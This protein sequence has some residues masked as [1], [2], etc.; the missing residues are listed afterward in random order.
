MTAPPQDRDRNLSTDVLRGL[1][2]VLVVFGHAGRGAIESA[3]GRNVEV[4]SFLDFAL[5]TTH[6]PVFFVIAG[7]Y[8]ERSLRSRSG[9]SYLASRFWDLVYPY[10]LWSILYWLIHLVMGRFVHINHPLTIDDLAAIGWKPIHVLWFLYALMAIQLIAVGLRR[11]PSLLLAGS[12][13]ALAAMTFSPYR[14]IAE[15]AA[16]IVRFCPFFAFGYW[17]AR[18]GAPLIHPQLGAPLTLIA[19]I[20]AFAFGCWQAWRLEAP[21]PVGLHTL[22]VSALG[23]AVMMGLAQA[24][25]S[26]GPMARHLA[27]IGV[28][29]MAIYLLHVVVL[30]LA[31]RGLSMLGLASPPAIIGVGTAVGVYGSL[32]AFLVLKRLR[33]AQP[34]GLLGGRPVRTS[35]PRSL[36]S[37]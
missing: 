23:V 6:M 9:P 20:A 21:G 4:L 16:V 1:A 11:F 36:E 27:W 15:I 26:L 13:A 28:S 29:S 2:I 17:L 5:Y 22:P 31:P 24:I 30:A 18:R 3:A 35:A 19:L 14:P 25:R 33:L 12:V 10:V 7:Y 8:M 37:A 32:A 34:L